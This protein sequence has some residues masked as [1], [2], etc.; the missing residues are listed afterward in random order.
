MNKKSI[1]VWF[2]LSILTARRAENHI[3]IYD[4]VCNHNIC[5]QQYHSI[6]LIE[7]TVDTVA[8]TTTTQRYKDTKSN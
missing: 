8:A 1:L 5:V 3:C 2:R 7:A 4:T 6:L